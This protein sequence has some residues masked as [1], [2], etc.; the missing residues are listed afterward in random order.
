M[1]L[2]PEGV[3]EAFQNIDKVN[4]LC[5]Y[6]LRECVRFPDKKDRHYI[7][8]KKDNTVLWHYIPLNRTFQE[9]SVSTLIKQLLNIYLCNF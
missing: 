7:H 9:V 3:F 1:S 5:V 8:L 2:I 4:A 6:D